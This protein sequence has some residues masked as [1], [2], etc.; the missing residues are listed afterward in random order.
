[1]EDVTDLSKEHGASRTIVSLYHVQS[2]EGPGGE[3]PVIWCAQTE[4]RGA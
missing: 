2:F 3:E 4:K 1:M